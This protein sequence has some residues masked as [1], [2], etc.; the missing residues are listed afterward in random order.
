MRGMGGFHLENEFDDFDTFTE[1]IR[2]WDLDYRQLDRGSFSCGLKQYGQE[3]IILGQ[4]HFS[5]ALLQSGLSPGV[6]RT[7]VIPTAVCTPMRWRRQLVTSQDVMIFPENGEFECVTTPGFDV[8]SISLPEEYLDQVCRDLELPDFRS[9]VHGVEVIQCDPTDLRL[10][11][12]GIEEAMS[13][14]CRGAEDKSLVSDMIQRELAVRTVSLLARPVC[15]KTTQPARLRDRVVKRA[16]QYIREH[17]HVP[18]TSA[19][20]CR[21]AKASE[22]TLEY[23]FREYFGISPKQ[24]LLKH[25]L[26]GVRKHLRDGDPQNT[27]IIS[28]ANQWGF[29]H[30]G[31]FAADYRKLFG[32][33]PS[34]T[35]KRCDGS[36]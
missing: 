24:F 18:M 19:A 9:L 4:A 36:R 12:G 29:W 11:L 2:A 10:L 3:G 8:F 17:G 30:M 6:L 28:I 27:K 15:R 5:R 1:T 25:R 20:L 35:L 34:E 13:A 7:I 22:R 16:V 14:W 32:E 21:V 26:N 31:Q 23:G 33:L